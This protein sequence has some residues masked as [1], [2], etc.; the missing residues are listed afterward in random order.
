MAA[1]EVGDGGHVLA[2]QYRNP[3]IFDG[4]TIAFAAR[5]LDSRQGLLL[6]RLRE[7]LRVLVRGGR[8]LILET[9]QP[10]AALWRWLFHRYVAWTVQP[11]GRALSGSPRAYAYLAHTIPRFYR[12]GELDALLFSAGAARVTHIRFGGGIAALHVAEKAR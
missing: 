8:L 10:E 5:N 4:V 7:C 3:G 9:S 6:N 2:V 11:L 12:A 1:D